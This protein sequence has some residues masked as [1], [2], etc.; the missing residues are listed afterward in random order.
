VAERSSAD[1]PAAAPASAD[2]SL[3]LVRRALAGREEALAALVDRLTPVVQAR[4]TRS[5]L[6]CRGR[7]REGQAREDLKDLTQEVFVA[8]FK[9]DGRTLRRWDPR[10][11]ASLENF[12]GC[13]AERQVIS[14]LRRPRGRDLAEAADAPE[15]HDP[16]PEASPERQTA[17]RELLQCL[18]EN[19]RRKL[20]PLGWTMFELLFVWDGSVEEVSRE[21]DMNREAVR[22]WR[23]RLRELARQWAE[24]CEKKG[25]AHG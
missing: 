7:V 22:K 20:S 15:P 24:A 4:V 14:Q 1:R 3:E 19:F 18:V 9:D 8:L 10:R 16:S 5:F 17:S 11:G 21:L 25:C 12:V 23:T 13:V 6:R 2:P